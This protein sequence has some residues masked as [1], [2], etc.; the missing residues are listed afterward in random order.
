MTQTLIVV[1]AARITEWAEKGELSPGYFNPDNRFKRVIVISLVEDSAGKEAIG[2]LCGSKE[3]S[4]I[5]LN[6][7]SVSGLLRS[8]GF[9]AVLMRHYV[10][11]EVVSRLP[12]QQSFV[13]RAYGDTFAGK[14]A[15]ILADALKCRSVASIHTTFMHL[16]SEEKLSLKNKCIRLLE[17]RARAFAHENLDVL[18]PVYSPIIASIPVSHQSKVCIIPNA[19]DVC[20]EDLKVSYSASGDLKVVTVGRLVPGK[21]PLPV[22]D[23]LKDLEGWHLTIVGNGPC[24]PSLKDWV[25]HNGKEDTVRFIPSMSN[26]ELVESLRSFD[27]FAAHTSYAEVPKTVIEAGL[28]GLPVILNQPDSFVAQ[29]YEDAPVLWCQGGA[30]SYKQVFE[31]FCASRERWSEIGNAS[32]KHFEKWFSPVFAGKRMADLL[33]QNA[34][35]FP[36][37]SNEE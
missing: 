10:R 34:N 32:R 27:V 8:V 29:E 11:R 35:D 23:G 28:V 24:L 9:S 36:H 2:Y 26:K 25:K 4:F 22:L 13:V 3:Y 1:V 33:S 6:L 30:E 17:R 5:S 18:A 31:R 7:L 14:F 15:A 37:S 12:E 21:N 16:P 19:V 20:P